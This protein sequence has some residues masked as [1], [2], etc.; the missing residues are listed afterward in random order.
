MPT[1]PNQPQP[2]NPEAN[3]ETASNLGNPSRSAQYAAG[4]EGATPATLPPSLEQ[5]TPRMAPSKDKPKPAERADAK[6]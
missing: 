2:K 3:P 4:D 5:K 6:V 1:P